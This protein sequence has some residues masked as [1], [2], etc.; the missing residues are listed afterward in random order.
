MKLQTQNNTNIDKKQARIMRILHSTE[1][2]VAESITRFSGSMQFAYLHAGWFL[3]WIL[4]NQGVFSSVVPVFDPFPYG[5]L[6]MIVSLEAIFLSTFIMVAQNRQI[7][8]DKFR[9]LEEDKEQHEEKIQEE[10]LEKD[11]EDLQED[12]QDIQEDVDTIQKD[13]DDILSAVSLIQQK[14]V[15]V[16]KV[17]SNLGKSENI[18]KKR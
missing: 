1:G 7:L 11:V 17:K 9:D 16:D 15:H 4:I 12:V 10:E 18:E 2:K 5:L 14:L 8:L 6:T 13:L 3:V